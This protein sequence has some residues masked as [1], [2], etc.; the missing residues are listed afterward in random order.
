MNLVIKPLTPDLAADFFD[1]FENR[2]FTDD[3]PYRCYCQVYQMSKEQYQDAYDNA[4]E[5]DVGRASREVA[6][7]QIESSILR[8]YLAFVD[9]VAIGWCNA[10]DRANYPAEQNYDV[11]F[12]APVEKREKAVVCFEI[13]PEHRGKGVATA[14][15]QQVIYDAKA[16]GYIAVVGF[17]VVRDE[18]YEWD[19]S[20]PVRLYEKV[21]FSKVSEK[22]GRMVMRKE[23][24]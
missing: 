1:F 8:G 7:R 24:V 16:E 14:L 4:K 13:A 23:F 12:H 18:R 3:S 21:G 5:S 2:A 15:L 9:G 20:G 22:G 10:N 6:E 17:P 11:P 19:C